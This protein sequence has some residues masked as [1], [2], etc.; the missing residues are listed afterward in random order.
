MD[1]E[2]KIS[3]EHIKLTPRRDVRIVEGTLAE[4]KKF[5]KSEDY[6]HANLTD[7]KYHMSAMEILRE[8]VF[9]N[10]LS[11]KFTKVEQ[12]AGNTS[13]AKKFSSNASILDNFKD[14]FESKSGEKF[15][16]EYETAMNNFLKEVLT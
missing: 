3:F 14:F 5:S 7:E 8:S 1:G 12:A 2:G 13:N 4:L 9:P 10:I 11:V 15:T 16:P 6:I